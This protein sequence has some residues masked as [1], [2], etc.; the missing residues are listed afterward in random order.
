MSLIC[1]V[2]KKPFGKVKN[3]RE[4]ALYEVRGSDGMGF[5]VSDFG[6]TLVSL[7]IPGPEGIVTDVVLGY[8]EG[9]KK[10]KKYFFCTVGCLVFLSQK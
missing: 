1:T 4:P 6:A 3:G 10:K 5:A 8:K 7:W 2:E 9:T